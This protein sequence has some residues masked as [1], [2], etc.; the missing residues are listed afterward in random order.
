MGSV[1]GAAD[2]EVT[3]FFESRRPDIDGPLKLVMD[4]IEEA[5]LVKNDR[6]FAKVILRKRHDPA[7]PRTEIVVRDRGGAT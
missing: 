3:F 4:A 7:N 1:S 5:R 2:L 6:Q